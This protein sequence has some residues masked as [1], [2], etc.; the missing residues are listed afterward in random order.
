[1]LEQPCPTCGYELDINEDTCPRC[2]MLRRAPRSPSTPFRV[3]LKW[4]MPHRWFFSGSGDRRSL[5]WFLERWFICICAFV[6]GCALPAF[7]RYAGLPDN[8]SAILF[9]FFAGA[10][11][12]YVIVRLWKRGGHR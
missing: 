12:G 10:A 3:Q 11:L 9:G 6:G 4:W 7:V 1:M 5:R 8:S 2:G